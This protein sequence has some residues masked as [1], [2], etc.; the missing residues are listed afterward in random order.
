MLTIDGVPVFEDHIG[1]VEDSLALDQRQI[2][3]VEEIKNRFRNI[4]LDVKAGVHEVAAAFVAR[5]RAE[6]DYLLQALIPGEG[7]PDV[8]R[9]HGIVIIG[10]YDAK[11]LSGTTASRERIFVCHPETEAEETAVCCANPGPPRARRVP[12]SRRHR[13]SRAAARVLRAGPRGRR[14]RRGHPERRHGDPREHQVPLSRRA[15]R[16]AARARSPAPRIP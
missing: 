10:P 14:L 16:R 7:V 13:R 11:G 3:A 12:P 1:G 2:T 4:R 5:S 6:G 9:L 15:R 8:P